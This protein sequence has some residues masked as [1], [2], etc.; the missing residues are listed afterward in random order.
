MSTVKKWL[1]GDPDRPFPQDLARLQ[2]LKGEIIFPT[3]EPL[4]FYRN[5]GTC[6]AADRRRIGGFQD[7]RNVAKMAALG[8]HMP[9]RTFFF[10]GIGLERERPY[11]DKTIRYARELHK[12]GMLVSVYVGG[13]IFTD[14]FFK[15]VPEAR[16]WCRKDQD[17]HPVTYADYQLMR[18]FPCLNNPG[19]RAYTKRV[20][21]I[22]VH[23]VQADEIFFDN[24]ILRHEPRSCRCDYCVAHVRE[25]IRKRFTLEQCLER[26]GVAEYPD[27]QPPIFSQASKPWRMDRVQ[28]PQIQDW[29]DHRVATVAEFY[30]DMADHV[31]RQRPSCVVGMNI[32]GI[33]GHN[34]A[35][36]HGVSHGAFADLIDFTCLDGYHPGVMA[37]GGI[38]TEVRVF[39]A[40]HSS[41]ISVVDGPATELELA[42]DQVHGYRK[43]IR[44][45]GWLN[46]LD[47]AT[48]YTP[49]AQFFRGHQR[50]FHERTHLHD[51]AV[52]RS[53]HS[54]DHNNA[55][56]HEQLMPFEMTLAMEKIPWSII[57]NKQIHDLKKHRII[58]LPEIQSLSNAWMEA[59][60]AFLRAGGGVIA[61]GQACAYDEWYRARAPAEGVGR[62]LGH[63]PAGKYEV[64]KVGK[65]TFVYV[66]EWD[67]TTRW[68][69]SD[70][71]GIADGKPVKDRA[72]FRRAI[73]DAC[74]NR[75]LT[76]RALG[77]DAVFMEA[78]AGA[79]GGKAGVDLHFVN[80]D[81]ANHGARL[82]VQVHVALPAGRKAARV[83]VTDA[84]DPKF[85]VREIGV[86]IQG[87]IAEFTVP[88][89]PVYTLAQV[90][91]A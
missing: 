50:L 23:E 38:N 74:G 85:P 91:F 66:P 34:R 5:R 16:E 30:R 75:P 54:T 17:G 87:G 57:F 58:A 65:G 46:E 56:V 10:K 26:Y 62:W 33:H 70:W 89:P 4:W 52:L 24:Q 18:W 13:T 8:L 28:R 44:G 69:M 20:L 53:E 79:K 40:S 12:R 25:M 2:K 31:K 63:P 77:P 22:A 32:K 27:V 67:V 11:I 73:N 36:D 81:A 7:P 61:T 83:Q 84:H 71:F 49:M 80:Y 55:K 64:A 60:D 76:F 41:H 43:F 90:T 1:R 15:E 48:V 29:I 51:V 6:T 19:Y 9:Q 59:L 21:D 86:T 45:H 68:D 14:Y 78:I 82:P 3:H 72:L 47:A 42:E 88:T 37:N 35:Y 39:K